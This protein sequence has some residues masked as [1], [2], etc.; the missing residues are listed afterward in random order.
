MH[1]DFE[2]YE[3]ILEDEVKA[4]NSIYKD[5]AS[6]IEKNTYFL[7]YFSNNKEYIYLDNHISELNTRNSQLKIILAKVHHLTAEHFAYSSLK[8]LKNTIQ[9][10]IMYSSLESYTNIVP[11]SLYIHNVYTFPHNAETNI[12]FIDEK[13]VNLFEDI[14]QCEI[15]RAHTP[16]L[17]QRK[18]I[19]SAYKL[20]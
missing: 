14:F 1:F 13:L 16:E 18:Y 12:K 3:V 9:P 19:T 10:E 7:K 5:I 17:S 8:A 11:E 6:E 2:L 20:F 15:L 4:F